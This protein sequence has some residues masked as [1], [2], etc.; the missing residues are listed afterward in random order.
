MTLASNPISPL[1]RGHPANARSRPTTA[2]HSPSSPPI[3]PLDSPLMA[4]LAE[5]IRLEREEDA[6]LLYPS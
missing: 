6:L 5:Q 4:T 3:E 2:A 1:M